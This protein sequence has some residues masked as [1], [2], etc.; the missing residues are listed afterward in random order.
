METS[1]ALLPAHPAHLPGPSSS[2]S[3]GHLGS[4]PSSA[5]CPPSRPLVQPVR[6]TPRQLS[7]Q[8]ILPAF[9][10]SRPAGPTDTSAAILPAHPA[11]LPGL[12]SSSTDGHLGSHPS[13][14]SWAPSRPLV[15]LRR[16]RP[17]QLSFQRIPPAFQASR[18]AGPMETSA[19][20]L[21]AHPGRL[22]GLPSSR[23][24]GDLG[25]HPSSSSWAIYC[26][27]ALRPDPSTKSSPA[28]DPAHPV[29][30]SG[31]SSSRSD[32]DLGSWRSGASRAPL[33]P[34]VRPVRWSPRPSPFQRLLATAQPF[35]PA[36]STKSS[37]AGLPARPAR[38]P[39]LPAS[40]SDGDLVRR[41]SAHPARL[42][43][44]PSS[45]TDGELATPPRPLRSKDPRGYFFK[46]GEGGPNLAASLLN[47]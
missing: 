10:A 37:P 11:R 16:W 5:S 1:A 6:R 29:H 19:A 22:P 20:I 44:L 12:S 40:R 28:G 25:N 42:P 38:L 27:R 30:L 36:P 4:H 34:F 23:S 32:G 21:P 41:S 17:R 24:D 7:F 31:V 9:Q 8:R 15:Q 26:P 18:P 33:R 35:R 14:G 43:G 39:G 46:R 2:R 45:S 13:S 3:D 47:R